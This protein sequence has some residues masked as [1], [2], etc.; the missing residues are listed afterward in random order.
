MYWTEM[1]PPE[2]GAGTVDWLYGLVG[3]LN[4][5]PSNAIFYVNVRAMS[6]KGNEAMYTADTLMWMDLNG[7]AGRAVLAHN[8]A[9]VVWEYSGKYARL[10][11]EVTA[12][13]RM[14]FIAPLWRPFTTIGFIL[15]YTWWLS[16]PA[17]NT[18]TQPQTVSASTFTAYMDG[19]SLLHGSQYRVY[20][21]ARN[22]VGIETELY[23]CNACMLCIVVLTHTL[24]S[25]S[26][27]Q[28][29]ARFC[30]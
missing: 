30:G 29:F 7:P 25:C 12:I 28:L 5:G 9:S 18:I 21:R 10:D 24:C 20:V 19:L 13:A 6:A 14:D 8:G 17:G 3:N 4:L 16:D 1:I 26:L 22:D 15:H 23:A 27:L 11:E 2:A